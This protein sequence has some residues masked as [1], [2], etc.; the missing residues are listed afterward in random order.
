MY[1][2][3]CICLYVYV[4]V[5]LC[6]YVCEICTQCYVYYNSY[7]IYCDNEIKDI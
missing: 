3:V 7:C 6:M 2:C 1:V 4:C 5:Y